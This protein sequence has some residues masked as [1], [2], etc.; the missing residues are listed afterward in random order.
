LGKRAMKNIE[1]DLK[2]VGFVG[3]IRS[4]TRL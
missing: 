4:W 3:E 2:L 1:R